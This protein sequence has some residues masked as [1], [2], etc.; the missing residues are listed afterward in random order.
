MRSFSLPERMALIVELERRLTVQDGV[1]LVQVPRLV[2]VAKRSGSRRSS[3]YRRC[4][5]QR[6]LRSVSEQHDEEIARA[7][8]SLTPRPRLAGG[9]SGHRNAR[10]A[11]RPG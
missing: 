9:R 6:R 2:D 8:R 5:T 10:A 3:S 4:L 11:P 7:H 1:H